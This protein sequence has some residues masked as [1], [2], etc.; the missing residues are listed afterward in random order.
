MFL[1]GPFVSLMKLQMEDLFF[2]QKETGAKRVAHFVSFVMDNYGARFQE[3]CFNI[4]RDIVFYQHFTIFRACSRGGGGPQVGE[5]PR[6]GEV[7]NLSIQPL[8]FS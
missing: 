4:S 6:L 5:V 8:F 2:G 7:T 3:H 1:V